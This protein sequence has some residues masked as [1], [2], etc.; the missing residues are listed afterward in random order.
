MARWRAPPGPLRVLGPTGNS[1]DFAYIDELGMLEFGAALH[2]G[3]RSTCPGRLTYRD[4]PGGMSRLV[5][6]HRS[7]P[8]GCMQLR[9]R[10]ALDDLA[11]SSS[12]TRRFAPPV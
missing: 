5:I 11:T 1:R 4:I 12:A 7:A 9:L 2:G 3:E 6:S 8:V 10:R